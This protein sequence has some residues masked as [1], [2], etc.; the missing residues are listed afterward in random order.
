M[1]EVKEVR[2]RK[3]RKAFL[4]FPLKLYKGNPYFVPPLY[5]DEKALFHKNYYYY[6]RSE[7]KFFLAY[8]D[9]KVVGRIQGIWQKDANEKWKQKRIRWTRFDSIDDP[10]VSHLLFEAVENYAKSK[11]M[12][13]MV[14]PLGFSDMEREGLLIEGFDRLV[15]F[16]EQYNYPYYQ[17]LVE[18]EGYVKEVDWTESILRA[19]KVKDERIPRLSALLMK[20]YN[21]HWAKCRNV[22]ELV[23]LYGRKLFDL[24]EESYGDLYQTVPFTEK[25]ITSLVKSFKLVLNLEYIFIIL[26]ERDEPVAFAIS[27]PRIGPALQK[28]QGHLTIPAVFRVL[29]AIRKPECIDLGL[30]GVSKKYL[31]TGIYYPIFN[32]L[33][34]SL[35]SGRVK[36]CETNLNLEENLA[37]TNNWARFDAEVVKRRRSYVKKLI[38]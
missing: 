26:N 18:K 8:Q 25:Q 19:P 11:G 12:E 9:G 28:S 36:E 24:V 17:N 6:E 13:E 5:I 30:V 21:L 23:R 27:F 35:H 14:G 29:K 10:R 16:E 33:L 37:I 32:F 38:Y 7:S 1:I 34:E 20:K 4:D 3:E 22:N 31:N 2:T 15:T